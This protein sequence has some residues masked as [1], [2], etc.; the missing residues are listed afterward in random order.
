MLEEHTLHKYV[1]KLFNINLNV[2]EINGERKMWN[3]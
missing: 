1:S 2:Q 3:V